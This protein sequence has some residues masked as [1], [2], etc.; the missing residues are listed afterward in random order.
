MYALTNG[1][2]RKV[3][4]NDFYEGIPILRSKE[5]M[6]EK[7]LQTTKSV[8]DKSLEDHPRTFAF[9]VDLH[10]P[11]DFPLENEPRL[12]ERF[13]SSFK[14]KVN[15][16]RMIKKQ[17]NPKAAETKIRYIRAREQDSSKL[18]HYH[19]M[20]LL[21]HD[22]FFAL[23]TYELG[24]DNLFNRLV[25]AWASALNMNPGQILGLVHIPNNPGYRIDRGDSESFEA[26]FSRASYLAKLSTKQYGIGRHPF[27]ASRL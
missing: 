9:R 14:S 3:L 19:F 6:V 25:E 17:S 27:G 13:V 2:L 15:H 8:F 16:S 7:Y 24:R 22:A 18:P 21:N 12:L 1:Y 23:G 11:S 10:L 20:F 26:A 5:G 4:S